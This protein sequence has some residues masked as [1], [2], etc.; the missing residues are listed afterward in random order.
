LSAI[1]VWICSRSRF[2]YGFCRVG[3]G[4]RCGLPSHEA[5]HYEQR[6]D[7]AAAAPG[8]AAPALHARQLV[9]HQ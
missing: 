4:E 3:W 6:A 9:H 1:L 7:P 2:K 8:G 5:R